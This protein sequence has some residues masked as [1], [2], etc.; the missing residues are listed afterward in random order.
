MVLERRGGRESKRG[1][2]DHEMW[3]AKMAKL[4]RDLKLG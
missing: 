4:Y 2:S 3:V 1:S